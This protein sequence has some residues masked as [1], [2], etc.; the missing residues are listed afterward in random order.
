[1]WA[2]RLP[3]LAWILGFNCS[4]FEGPGWECEDE[5]NMFSW[6]AER[7]LPPC[8]T[9]N[10]HQLHCNENQITHKTNVSHSGIFE[11]SKCG[12]VQTTRILKICFAPIA[13]I[14]DW[15]RRK[16][17]A[18][19]RL[20]IGHD[21]LGTNL[22]HIG[23]RPDPYCIL[24]SLRVPTDRNHLGQCTILF[25]RTECERYWEART[26]MMETWLCFFSITIICDYCLFLGLSYLIW[27]F[28]F[29]FV[30]IV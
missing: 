24:C 22:H 26:K 29:F 21:C 16:A 25:N 13:K 19:F 23:I 17:V 1:M 3:I 12:K 7:P 2:W 11:C 6:N 30:F 4:V 15:P 27:G 20:C 14:P 5:V 9:D 18:E 10:W 28:F 8:I